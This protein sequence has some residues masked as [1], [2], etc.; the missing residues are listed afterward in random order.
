QQHS[1][2][3][4]V[5]AEI[6]GTRLF[7][8]HKQWVKFRPLLPQD[9]GLRQDGISTR[10]SGVDLQSLP[11]VFIGLFV[12]AML[13]PGVE[14]P[15]L[16]QRIIGSWICRECLLIEALCL[17]LV[18]FL[19]GDFCLNEISLH[20]I[21]RNQPVG[22]LVS[23]LFITADNAWRLQVKLDHPKERIRVLR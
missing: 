15:E 21:D 11:Q 4:E 23:L 9:Q 12:I 1:R 2:S 16:N 10:A 18:L 19:S 3:L 5:I 22:I 14:A 7:G 6:L 13:L 17:I 8:L 20:W